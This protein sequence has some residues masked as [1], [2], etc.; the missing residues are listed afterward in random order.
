MYCKNSGKKTHCYERVGKVCRKESKKCQPMR[1]KGEH[2]ADVPTIASSTLRSMQRPRQQRCRA[3]QV[4]RKIVSGGRQ[5][6]GREYQNANN[7]GEHEVPTTQSS[8]GRGYEEGLGREGEKVRRDAGGERETKAGML[9]LLLE[10]PAL[11]ILSRASVFGCRPQNIGNARKKIEQVRGK[12]A[13]KKIGHVEV[14]GSARG[15]E[16]SPE[17]RNLRVVVETSLSTNVLAHRGAIGAGRAARASS[18]YR[19]A[20]ENLFALSRKIEKYPASCQLLR[21]RRFLR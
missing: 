19:K 9:G 7:N 20:N 18:R 10:I 14:V 5:E 21:T 15:S 4:Y 1:L 8:N 2:R 3:A 11:F 12:K 13:A 16:W 6:R 17:P